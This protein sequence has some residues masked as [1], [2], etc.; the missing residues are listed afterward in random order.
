MI[1][2]KITKN[3]NNK[4]IISFLYLMINNNNNN[5]KYLLSLVIASSFNKTSINVSTSLSVVFGN[6]KSTVVKLVFVKPKIS[7]RLR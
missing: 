3:N 6:F 5:N 4:K 1:W 7:P 2:N